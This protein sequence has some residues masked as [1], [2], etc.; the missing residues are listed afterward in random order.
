M[1]TR[2]W[3]LLATPLEAEDSPWELFHENSKNTPYDRTMPES[4][5]QAYM[6]QMTESLVFEG[7]S[8]VKLPDVA[9]P[10]TSLLEAM[11]GIAAGGDLEPGPITLDAAS[12]LLKYGCGALNRDANGG[13]LRKPR[14]V[15]SEGLLF[16]VELY[17]QIVRVPGLKPGLYHYYPPSHS[18]HLVR[19]GDLSQK[20]AAGLPQASWLQDAAMTVFVTAMPERSVLRYGDRGYR[21]VLLECGGV[22]QNLNLAAAALDL[23]CANTGEFCDGEIDD[24]LDFDGL[25]ISTFY[26]VGI[27]K[28]S[29]DA[30]RTAQSGRT[31]K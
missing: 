9:L 24:V 6:A 8:E 30:E 17:L 27:G 14:S 7:F 5:A 19:T 23:K 20:L 16:A 11:A 15:H 13:P 3:D 28:A 29:A 1:S 2:T 4:T 31:A 21:Y 12:A 26:V 10:P 22:V 25:S 18:L